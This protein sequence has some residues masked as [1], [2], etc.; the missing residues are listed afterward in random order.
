MFHLKTNN[1]TRKLLLF[2]FAIVIVSSTVAQKANRRNAVPKQHEPVIPVGF[3]DKETSSNYVVPTTLFQR[4]SKG[5]STISKTLIG[6]SRNIFGGLL[7][8]QTCLTYN[9]E[10]NNIMFTYRGNDKGTIALFGNGNDI[11]HSMSADKGASFTQKM[12]MSNGLGNRYTSGVFYNP[13]GNTDTANAYTLVAGP[14][15]TSSVW[16]GMYLHSGK[17]DGTGQDHQ[18]F[19]T[20]PTYLELMRNGLAATGDGKFHISTIGNT[21]D[22]TYFLT[23]KIFD[24]NGTWNATDKKVDWG[25]KGE[26]TPNLVTA[27]SNNRIYMDG[28]YTQAAWSKDGSVGYL[29]M[30]G[31]DN[32]PADKP[33]YG[34]MIWKSTNG[35]VTW[36]MLDYFNWG[37]LTAITDWIFPI[38]SDSTVYKP[39][40]EE[41]SIVVDANSKPHIFGLVRGGYSSNLDSLGYVYVR[42][43]T[44]TIMDGNIVELYMDDSNAWQANWI[45][46]ISAESVPADKSPY[47][48]TPDNTGW[49]HRISASVSNDGSAVFCTWTDS[50]WI[51][52]GTEAYDLNP[53]LKGFGRYVGDVST[54]VGPIN[55]TAGT[56]LW[57]LAFFHFTSPQAITVA[58]CLLYDLPVTITDIN[59]SG[60]QAQEPV[61]HYYVQG[62]TFPLICEGIKDHQANN[63]C[64]ASPCYPNPFTGTTNVDVTI[65]KPANVTIK[66]CDITGQTVSSTNYGTMTSGKHSLAINGADLRSGVYFYSITVGDQTI[67][68]KMIVK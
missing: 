42:A 35:G 23:G 17:Y 57:G 13:T 16:S 31:A 53:D 52:W 2:L 14:V 29:V 44:G 68:N 6:S 60:L 47:V 12:A 64:Q 63:S 28:S 19:T 45:D 38:I 15:T 43:S 36:T 65:V 56:D 34:P 11:V 5:T 24:M 40:F 7:S 49:D 50:D 1:M 66:V 3:S 22:G 27:P 46:S 39:Y 21:N 20:D 62:I 41:A 37:S 61:Y 51:F 59:T 30:I 32:R 58:P 8:F 4:E 55:F 33:T 18:E 26:I 25:A 10:L 48:N 54:G 67:N 9:E